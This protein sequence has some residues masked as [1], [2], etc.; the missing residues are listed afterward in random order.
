MK[1]TLVLGVLVGVGALS[2]SVAAQRGADQPKVV[3][4]DKVKDTL[5]VLQ[6]GGGNTAAFITANGVVLVDT[7][8]P[9]WGQPLLDKVKTITN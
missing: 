1:R 9:G 3:E 8:N 7:K 5:Y 4:V 6:G 2:L